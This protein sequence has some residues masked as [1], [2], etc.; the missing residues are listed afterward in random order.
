MVLGIWLAM[1]ATGA[2]A[3]TGV[4]PHGDATATAG[5]IELRFA[6]NRPLPAAMFQRSGQLWA[7]FPKDAGV[8]EGWASQERPELAQWLQPIDTTVT[9]DALVF[10][11]RTMR[12]ARF[13]VAADAEGWTLR[14]GPGPVLPAAAPSPW[15]RDPGAGQ[16]AVAAV[17]EIVHLRD[18]DTGERLV[19]L[20]TPQPGLHGAERERLVDLDILPSLQGLVWHPLADD[21]R[22]SVAGGRLTVTR[23]GGLRLGPAQPGTD[24][25][26]SAHA[27]SVAP[28]AAVRQ[29]PA[30]P[31]GHDAE[32]PADADGTPIARLGLARLAAL[33]EAARREARAGLLASLRGLAGPPR[34][35]ARLE[36]ARLYLADALGAEARTALGMIQAGDLAAPAGERLRTARLALTGAAEALAGRHDPALASLLDHAL[37]EDPEVALWRAYAAARAGRWPLATQEWHRSGG[38]PAAYPDP[39]Q[40]RLGPELAAALVEQG[41]PGEARTL[42]AQLNRAERTVAYQERLKLLEGMAQLR[43]GRAREAEQALA[44]AAQASGDVALRARFLL[45][46][47][48]AESGGLTAAAAAAAME[49]ERPN[50]RGHP[51]EARMLGRLAELQGAA[52]RA[53]TAI[54]TRRDAVARTADA[55]AAAAGR[56]TLGR[57][58]AGLLADEALPTVTRLA[59]YRTHGGLLAAPAAELRASLGAAAA[60]AGFTETAASLLDAAGAAPQAAAGRAALAA[61]L[62]ARGET[63]AARGALAGIGDRAPVQDL[64]RE[65]AARE[66]LAAGDPAR[67][68][69]AIRGVASAGGRALQREIAAAQGDWAA[70]ARLAGRDVG[71]GA[72]APTPGPHEAT[73]AVWLALAHARLGGTAAPGMAGAMADRIAEPELAALLRLASWPPAGEG[74]GG[75]QRAATLRSELARLPGPVPVSGE[76]GAPGAPLRTA[77]ARSSP[78]G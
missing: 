1:A 32:H 70:V 67:A 37:D 10:R 58:V 12:P 51:W 65:L 45:A 39:L 41:E 36:L 6:G 7:V 72:D 75:K 15:R 54:A 26:A 18:P 52:G 61:A 64:E 47:A 8:A 57:E 66:A 29:D 24:V 13:E 4:G 76:P 16:L 42:L 34:A 30:P 60:R 5:G 40:A 48:R 3:T 11:W 62:A 55:A 69:Q 28:A 49:A 38:L 31:S 78:A 43:Q 21:V 14:V 35:Q 23:P 46:S 56:A 73:A 53:A 17:G 44:A 59:L 20:L 33:D 74:A 25:A 2:A 27:R 71:A 50:W 22:A 19:A 9:E 77:A 63:D 68:A